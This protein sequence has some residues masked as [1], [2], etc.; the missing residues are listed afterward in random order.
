MLD[1]KNRE[2]MTGDFITI[3]GAYFNS[4]NGLWFVEHASDAPD[5][6]SDTVWL[7]KVKKSGELCV[8]KAG[9]STSLPL[10][11]YC[12]DWKKNRAAREHD[13]VN[14]R[15]E[16]TDGINTH[17][18]VE[19]YKE[20][21]AGWEERIRQYS[22]SS[23][24]WQREEA[25]K[26]RGWVAYYSAVIDRLAQNAEQPK[27]KAPEVGVKFLLNGIKVDGGRLIP[28]WYGIYEKE[29]HINAKD[30]GG[31]LP[32]QYF[33]VHNDSDIMTDYFDKDGTTLTPEHPL[34]KYARYVALKA[35]V[36]GK[37][38][39]SPTDELKAEFA[40]MKDPGQPTAADYAA[41]DEM[42]KAAQ[43]AKIAAQK[44]EELAERERVLRI[45]N[46][47]KAYIE[48]VMEQHPIVDGDPVVTICWSEHPAFYAWD[49]DELKMSVAAAE[50]ILKHFDEEQHNTRETEAG[51]G[52][53]HKTKFRIDF[54]DADGE[55]NSYEGRYDLG[56]NDGGMIEHIRAH[57]RYYRTHEN[58]KE[59]ENPPEELSDTEKF[60]DWLEQYTAGG[61]IVNV[62]VDEKVIDL[63]LYR[64]M[65]QKKKMEQARRDWQDIMDAVS[66]LTDEQI[67]S[68]IFSIDPNDRD[69]LDVA[70][71]FLQ[72]LSR[73]D[74]QNALDVF[75]R[76]Q[77]NA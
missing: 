37:D 24:E 9:N 27:Q 3:S 68:A 39:R 28:C 33:D 18:A 57:G 74:E 40:R 21:I 59:I 19:H 60:A 22:M 67:E 16:V 73:R 45:K 72:E 71:F 8:G 5:Y 20:Q 41:I 50:I 6:S 52:W 34:Y 13:A 53:Y 65:E 66:M 29:V 51:F 26:M 14:L 38:W 63:L 69:K 35:L 44:A 7:R 49:D 58:G 23:V 77:N 4:N 75:R 62:T 10:C 11:Y 2:I 31:A 32:R 43:E 15:Y 56:D 17:Y 47:G 12:S 64:K 76:W 61:R 25:E 1:S 42:R 36:A 30:Y 54:V 48:S 55:R 46:N 70:R